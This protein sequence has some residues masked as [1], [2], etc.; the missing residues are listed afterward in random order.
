MD[1]F[2]IGKTKIPCK[3]S[4]NKRLKS[5]RLNVTP[6]GVEIEVPSSH[7]SDNDEFLRKNEEWIFNKWYEL[8]HRK[9]DNPWP[10]EFTSGAK[11]LFLDRYEMLTV[12]LID[13]QEVAV[14]HSIR[15]FE[16][17]APLN[18][19]YKFHFEEVQDEFKGFFKK[20]LNSIFEMVN[21]KCSSKIGARGKIL[22]FIERK[23]VW[24]LCE[25]DGT[26]KLDWRLV[27]LPKYVVEYVIAHEICH[28]V[29]R[30]HSDK[31]WSLVGSVVS[32][33]RDSQEYIDKKVNLII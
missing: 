23:D 25:E 6:L 31:F 29:E 17:T 20:E 32:D 7:F 14:K 18:L 4:I 3:V 9:I 26:I 33:Y 30:N 21:E 12:K 27:F 5:R 1:F 11:V 2:E 22:K 15:G 24:A 16:V 10:E 8:G 28:L 19:P 13:S